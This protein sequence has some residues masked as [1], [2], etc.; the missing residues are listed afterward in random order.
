MA[1][2]A[3]PLIPRSTLAQKIIMENYEISGLL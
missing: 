3:A 2:K 1:A